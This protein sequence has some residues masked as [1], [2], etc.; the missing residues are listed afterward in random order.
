M[1]CLINI[2]QGDIQYFLWLLVVG[3]ISAI[4]TGRVEVIIKIT[5]KKIVLIISILK[6]KFIHKNVLIIDEHM[7]K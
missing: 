5:A 7:Y 4:L 1:D 6:K 2:I 3:M